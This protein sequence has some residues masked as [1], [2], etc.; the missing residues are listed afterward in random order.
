MS[1][2]DQVKVLATIGSLAQSLEKQVLTDIQMDLLEVAAHLM[3]N[4][5]VQSTLFGREGM[6]PA[7]PA[8]PVEFQVGEPVEVMVGSEQWQLTTVINK[9]YTQEDGYFY[10]TAF[11]KRDKWIAAEAL[12]K[13]KK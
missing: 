9:Q 13:V 5:A 12:R 3:T 10:Q 8:E 6:E 1:N 4:I 7:K 11:T 2:P